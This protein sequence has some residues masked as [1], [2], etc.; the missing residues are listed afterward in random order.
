MAAQLD[1]CRFNATSSGTVDFVYNSTISGY[2]SP[3]AANAVTALTYEYYATDGAG[4]WEIG[5]ATLTI[6]GGGTVFTFAR[7][8]VYYNS[9]GTGTKTTGQSGAGTKISFGSA[10]QVAIVAVK[11]SL[12]LFDEAS[13]FT[14]AQRA[15]GRANLGAAINELQNITFAVSASAGA[16]TIALKDANGN[17]ATASTPIALSFRNASL[18]ASPNTPTTIEVQTASSVVVPSTSTCGTTSAVGCRL[19]I[20]GWNDGG[21]FRLGVFNASVTNNIYALNESGVASSLQVVAAGNAA[22]QHYTAGAAVTNK[23]FRILGFVDWNASGV[24]TAGT[25]T[26]TNLNEIHTFGPGTPRPGAPTGNSASFSTTSN[27]TNGTSSFVSTALTQNLNMSSAA[28]GARVFWSGNCSNTSIGTSDSILQIF[29]GSVAVPPLCGFDAN[30]V[31]I[32][33]LA[34]DFPNTI[35]LVTYTLKIK[36]DGGVGTIAFPDAGVVGSAGFILVEEIMG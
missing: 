22:G 19:W 26:T 32:S 30:H 31:A 5:L 13:A 18:T 3:A 14:A 10:P 17:D 11:E 36:N 24:A 9:A 7:T 33:A 23:A 25:W 35:G 8:T 6:S 21:T 2:Q 34:T 15:Q 29:R 28:N 1:N 4:A 16:L 20:I 12:L 27:T